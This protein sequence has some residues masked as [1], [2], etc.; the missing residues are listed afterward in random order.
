MSMNLANFH[1][2]FVDLLNLKKKLFKKFNKNPMFIHVF[3]KLNSKRNDICQRK[4]HIC[5]HVLSLNI[6]LSKQQG[7]K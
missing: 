6:A 7:W 5:L 4:R 1:F 3:T 2:K